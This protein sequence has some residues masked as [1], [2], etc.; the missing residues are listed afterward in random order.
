MSIR[1]LLICIVLAA[2]TPVAADDNWPQFRGASASGVS[3]IAG[4]L[5]WNVPASRNVRWKVPIAG[6]GHSSPVI[7]GNRV[8]I[9]TAVPVEGGD[10]RLKTGLYGDIGP[11][12]ETAEYRWLVL[13]FDKT[14]GTKTWER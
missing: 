11:V 10:E 7:W 12:E 13:C 3:P 8:F 6:L 2:S 1:R 5:Q 14:T 4:P 9:T